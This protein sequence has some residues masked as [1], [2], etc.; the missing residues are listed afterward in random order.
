MMPEALFFDTW[1][2]VALGYRKDS[3]HPA[4]LALY[5]EVTRSGIPVVTSDFVL[6]EVAT[7]LF[8]RETFNQAERFLEGV[9]EASRTGQLQREQVSGERF[10]RAWELRRRYRDKPMI[11]FTDLTSMVLMLELGLTKIVTAHRHFLHVG[12]GFQRVPS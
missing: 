4:V 12:L 1:G 6:D 11:S 3:G 2:W 5:Q 10:S 7:L 9:F 8:Q